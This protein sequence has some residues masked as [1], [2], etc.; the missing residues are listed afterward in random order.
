MT[1][2]YK[3]MRGHVR[4]AM[5]VFVCLGLVTGRLT[6]KEKGVASEVRAIVIGFHCGD[7]FEQ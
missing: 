7:G 1:Q 6:D 4:L 2:I 3:A 5:I